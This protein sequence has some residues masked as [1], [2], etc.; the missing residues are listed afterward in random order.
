M[1]GPWSSPFE[2]FLSAQFAELQTRLVAEHTADIAR[3]L[4][5]YASNSLST[6]ASNNVFD[7]Q[8]PLKGKFTADPPAPSLTVKNLEGLRKELASQSKLSRGPRAQHDASASVRQGSLDRKVFEVGDDL[9]VATYALPHRL[10]CSLLQQQMQQWQKPQEQQSQRDRRQQLASE[11]EKQQQHQQQHQQQEQQQQQFQQKQQ[12]MRLQ[13][14]QR[15]EEHQQQQRQQQPLHQ[16]QQEPELRAPTASNRGDAGHCVSFSSDVFQAAGTTQNRG[17]PSFCNSIPSMRCVPIDSLQE[18]ST[19]TASWDPPLGDSGTWRS[20]VARARGE[21]FSGRAE[22]HASR[23]S[24][25][26]RPCA[27]GPMEGG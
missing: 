23:S 18:S 25:S 6:Q 2:A 15:P 14:A 17:S 22:S 24:D 13:Q 27:P 20:R 12:P 26:L 9:D 5:A 4:D 3:C 16:L 19:S 1:S 21:A 10:G 7:Q 11:L 8:L